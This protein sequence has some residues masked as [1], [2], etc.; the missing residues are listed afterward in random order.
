MDAVSVC[1]NDIG[2][3]YLNLFCCTHIC[4][5][6][7]MVS[8]AQILPW[9]HIQAPAPWSAM[10][11]KFRDCHIL[12]YSSL[13]VVFD[14]TS[15]RI[16]TIQLPQGVENGDTDTIQTMWGT[17]LSLWSCRWVDGYSIWILSAGRCVKLMRW[18]K[19]VDDWVISIFLWWSGLPHFLH[20]KILLQGFSSCLWWYV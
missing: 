16:S 19:Q 20:S 13:I 12:S 7:V 17:T 2:L 18:R 8:G 9:P 3:S 14:L 11:T 10:G 15:S 1:W 6:I 4:C 5:N